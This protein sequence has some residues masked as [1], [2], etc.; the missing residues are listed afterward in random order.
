MRVLEHGL[1]D[2]AARV[3]ATFATSIELENWK[4]IIDVIEKQI[5]AQEA[6]PKSPQKSED[7]QFYTKAAS[8]FWHFKDAWR[9]HV[10]HA[11]EYYDEAEAMNVFNG[12]K[13]LMQQLATRP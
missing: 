3:G 1:R 12:V 7:L 6:L 5:R 4:N 13:H 11:R 10:S 8:Q 2:L 9:N